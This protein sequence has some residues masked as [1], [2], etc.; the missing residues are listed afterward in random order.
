MTDLL[1]LGFLAQSDFLPDSNVPQIPYGDR[2]D[3]QDHDLDLTSCKT[4]YQRSRQSVWCK[5]SNSLAEV[6]PWLVLL[7]VSFVDTD[8]NGFDLEADRR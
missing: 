2:M 6:W 5:F 8:D 3:L 1:F 7:L 4:R